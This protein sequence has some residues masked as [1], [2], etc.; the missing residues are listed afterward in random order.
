MNANSSLP[1]FRHFI[2]P[3]AFIRPARR[4]EVKAGA[5]SF[6]LSFVHDEF[7]PVW[8]AKLRHPTDRCLGLLDIEGDAALFEFGNCRV[9]I[10]HL[11]RDGRSIARRLPGWMTTNANSCRTK[12]VF[13]PCAAHCG[14]AWRKLERFLIKFPGPLG[15][16]DSDGNKGHLICNH[17]QIPFS[18]SGFNLWMINLF[19]SGSCTT[20]M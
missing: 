4:S 6:L 9:D 12:V 5:L 10:L 14:C 17:V 8:I 18:F 19:P 3:S 2:I 1:W 13:N 7:V 15:I 16:A 11:E 20:A